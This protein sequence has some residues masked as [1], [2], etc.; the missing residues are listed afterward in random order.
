[1]KKNKKIFFITLVI[2]LAVIFLGAVLVQ[3]MFFVPASDI[4]IPSSIITPVIPNN[5]TPTNTTTIKESIILPISINK[6]IPVPVYPATYPKQLR[7]PLIKV[8]AK[9]QY[10]GLSANEKMAT[11]NNFT[12]VGW[13]QNGVIPGNK[14]SAV[15]DGHVDNGLAF[16]AV[17]ANLGNLNIGDDI[18]IDTIGGDTLHFQVTNIKN[19]D[20]D[21]ETS[22]IF[23][24]NDGNY[25]KLITCAGTWSI[26]HRTHDQRLVITAEQI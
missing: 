20:A 17:F 8:D 23:N 25:L 16:P 12:D 5:T 24:Q 7:I 9:I 21:A 3:A 18:Y 4:T 14:G 2:V 10:I 13:F 19:Y 11:P 22:E 15:I 1:M 26:L 6:N